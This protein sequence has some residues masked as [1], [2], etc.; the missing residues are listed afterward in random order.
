MNSKEP[1]SCGATIGR[2]AT[3]L[4]ILFWD[5]G[6]PHPIQVGIHSGDC[7]IPRS[8]GDKKVVNQVPANWA[9]SSSAPGSSNR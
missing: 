6:Q 9:T 8:A 3:L 7:T 4:P 1:L 2:I 5:Y